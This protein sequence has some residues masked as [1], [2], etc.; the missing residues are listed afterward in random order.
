MNCKE[1]GMG[2][3]TLCASPRSDLSRKLACDHSFCDKCFKELIHTTADQLDRHLRCCVCAKLTRMTFENNRWVT[4]CTIHEGDNYSRFH[5]VF[6]SISVVFLSEHIVLRFGR[7]LEPR[8]HDVIGIS[9]GPEATYVAVDAK[10][11]RVIV[12]DAGGNPLTDF[13][14]TYK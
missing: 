1:L 13:A 9:R 14:Y 5:N 10:R 7:D 4:I 3:C 11:K 12:F 2:P 8:L 6:R